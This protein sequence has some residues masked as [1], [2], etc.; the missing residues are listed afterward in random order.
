MILISACLCGCDCKYNGGNNADERCIEMLK[1]GNAIPVCPEQLGGLN[2]PRIPAE[3][4]GDKVISKSG[5]DVTKEFLKGANETLKLAKLL[6]I[7]KAILKEK[8]PSCGSRYIYD[9]SFKGK[10]IKGEGL[11]TKIL[12]ENGIEVISEN[13]INA[14]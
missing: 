11:T 14:N 9:G 10:K 5:A 6:N 7:K 2:T 3:I 1:S 12:R 13:D 4:V 8:S